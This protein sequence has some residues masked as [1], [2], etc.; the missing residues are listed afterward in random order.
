MKRLLQEYFANSLNL[1]LAAYKQAQK[2]EEKA[3]SSNKA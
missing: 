3:F 2:K 1:F